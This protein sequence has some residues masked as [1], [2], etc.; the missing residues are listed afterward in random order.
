MEVKVNHIALNVENI[1]TTY[2]WF[3]KYFGFNEILMPGKVEIKAGIRKGFRCSI[4]NKAGDVLELNQYEEEHTTPDNKKGAINHLSFTVD[5]VEDYYKILLEDGFLI[6]GEKVYN[7][8]PVKILYFTGING[9]ELEL[10]E[11][12]GRD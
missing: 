11:I 8:G 9:I 12:V 3:K 5:D 2:E 7:P 10:I 4:G 6:R 1:E